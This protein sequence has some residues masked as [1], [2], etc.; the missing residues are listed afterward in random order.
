MPLST[1]VSSQFVTSDRVM[2]ADRVLVPVNTVDPTVDPFHPIWH[3]PPQGQPLGNTP[4]SCDAPLT[5]SNNQIF[6]ETTSGNAIYFADYTIAIDSGGKPRVK[7][8]QSDKAK[9]AT[10]L[11]IYLTAAPPPIA[12]GASANPCPPKYC[13]PG[14]AVRLYYSNGTQHVDFDEVTF[15]T[16]GTLMC[17]VHMTDDHTIGEVMEAVVSDDTD[18]SH[19]PWL[20]VTQTILQV[21]V[22]V[23]TQPGPAGGGRVPPP[24]E[25]EHATLDTSVANESTANIMGVNRMRSIWWPPRPT[26]PIPDPTPEPPTP[27]YNILAN[28]PVTATIRDVW[29]SKDNN[30]DILGDVG[31]TP[32]QAGYLEKSVPGYDDQLFQD[33]N[34]A[35]SWYYLPHAFKIARRDTPPFL[36]LLNVTISGATMDDAKATVFFIAV[37]VVDMQKLNAAEKQ[38]QAGHPEETV[39]L[40]PLATP[41]AIKYGL[42]LPGTPSFQDRSAVRVA[43]DQPLADSLPQMSLGDFQTA[44]ASLTVPVAQ[45]LQGTITV[46]ISPT[47]IVDVPLIARADDFPGAYFQQARTVDTTSGVIK[48]TL[49]N[50]IENAVQVDALP[51]RA[52]RAST[53]VAC[54]VTYD[55][56]LPAKIA[57][58]DDDH[59]TGG[60]LTVTVT[61][62]S[63][64][65][66]DTLS[67][68]VDQSQCHVV[69]DAAGLLRAVLD[70]N[71]PIKTSTPVTVQVPALLFGKDTETDDS[72]KIQIIKMTFLNGNT[73]TF[74]RPT[75]FSV[76]LVSPDKAGEVDVTVFDYL[77]HQASNS[78]KYKLG[79]T[80]LTGHTVTDS[81]WRTATGDNFILDLP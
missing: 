12:A 16:D 73:I 44:F 40:Q 79:I 67:L 15:Q 48:L 11:T 8:A 25:I 30:A 27:L 68:V 59:P 53:A 4:L 71:V 56:P 39:T 41:G 35:K 1:T 52:T 49:T 18:P 54:V 60:T 3:T 36:P 47:N 29:F 50:A 63:G 78:I 20:T 77:L 72:K 80:Y 10:T 65:L 33:Q 19:H 38:I 70:P 7:F 62:G 28:Q 69:P 6:H 57:A 75:D 31:V 74:N 81:D 61:P 5:G 34:D 58:A 13:A 46:P 23:A 45:Y 37:P 17:V 26:P 43:L 55:P 24:F 66:D 22:L 64:P 51:I 32:R 21:G 14:P 9:A 76:P 42:F 2:V